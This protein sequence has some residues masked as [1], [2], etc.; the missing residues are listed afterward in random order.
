METILIVEDEYPIS[1]VLKVYLRKAHFQTELVSNGKE[2]L[3]KFDEVKPALV[4]LDVMLPGIDGWEI[5]KEIRRKSDCPVIMLTALGEANHRVDGLNKGADDYISKPFIG[6]E[7][8]AR[9]KAVL[10]RVKRDH[11]QVKQY[12][13]LAID[14]QAHRVTVNGTEI[15]LIP[16]DL[17]LLL[18]LAEHPNQTFTRDQLIE[19]VWGWEY[20]G[21]D[22]AV[23]L[24]I[25]RLRKSLKDW[26][27]EEGEIRTLRGLGY[28]L[29]VKND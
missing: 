5:L 8:V 18:F 15:S 3:I 4:L 6:D 17:S 10:R 14:L 20:E 9:V 26:P 13:H 22:R 28:Q 29:S 25:K 16:R 21:S 27:K 19:H 23:D 7:V 12:G 24:S 2:A 11:H 1:Q